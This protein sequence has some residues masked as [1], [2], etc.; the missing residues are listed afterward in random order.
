[1]QQ[2]FFSIGHLLEDTFTIL[3]AMGWLPVIGIT[4]IMSIGFLFWMNL[5]GKYNRK[6]KQ[7]NS[8][9]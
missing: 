9:A 4:A 5:Q 7:D 1:M 3:V 6:A 2:T 8:L